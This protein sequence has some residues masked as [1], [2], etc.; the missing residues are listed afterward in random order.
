MVYTVSAIH[1]EE[2]LPQ[3]ECRNFFHSTDFFRVVAKTPRQKPYMIVVCDE[4]KKIVAHMLVT[5][6]QRGSLIPPYLFT[7]GRIYGEGEYAP[8]VPKEQLFRMML[9]KV[10]EVLKM[11]L[12]LYIEFSNISKKMFA[13]SHFKACGYF[14]IRWMQIHNSL[15]SMKPEDRLP[16]KT[17]KRIKTA[18]KQ[19]VVTEEIKTEE[20]IKLFSKLIKLYYRFKVLTYT[21]ENTQLREMWKTGLARMFG[22]MY[23][24]KM[25]GCCSVIYSEENAYLWYHAARSKTYPMQHPKTMCTWYAIKMAYEQGYRHIY[26]MNAGLPFRKSRQR[27]FLLGFGGKPTS[28]YRWFRCTI[29]W[30]NKLLSWSYRE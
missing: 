10:N 29:P 21:P 3:I 22:C 26:F 6:R 8:E 28:T 14:P 11:K 19:G 5:L 20:G 13:Y 25:I 4:E 12:C 24:G 7:Q 30:I 1:K 23:R 16:E 18:M 27:E 15:H 9:E 17:A 2:D